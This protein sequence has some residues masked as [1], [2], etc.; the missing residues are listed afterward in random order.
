M[1]GVFFLFLAFAPMAEAATANAIYSKGQTG[2]SKTV[3][4]GDNVKVEVASIGYGEKLEYQELYIKGGPNSVNDQLFRET[5]QGRNEQ[6]GYE[7]G[8]TYNLNTGN[9]DAGTYTIEFVAKGRQSSESTSTLSLTIK[10]K[11]PPQDNNAP[12]LTIDYPNQGQTYNSQVTELRYTPTDAEGNLDKCW[13]STNGGQTNSSKVNCNDG[14]QN[15]FSNLASQAGSN[16]WTVWASDT[17]G[18]VAKESVT[19]TYDKSNGGGNGDQNAP[20]VN[21]LFPKSATYLNLNRA[22]FNVDDPE[23][24]LDRCY[25]SLDGGPRIFVQCSEVPNLNSFNINPSAGK[26]TLRVFAEDKAGNLGQDSVA[27]TVSSK[28]GG[29]GD[30]KAPGINPINPQEGDKLSNNQ[31]ELEL[32]TSE[33]AN[34]TYDVFDRKSNKYVVRGKNLPSGFSKNHNSALLSLREGRNYSVTYFAVDRSGNQK[35]KSLKFSIENKSKNTQ[36]R[37]NPGDGS[38]N[39]GESKEGDGDDFIPGQGGRYSHEKDEYLDQ[40]DRDRTRFVDKKNG[41]QGKEESLFSGLNSSW[42]LPL[43][44]TLI[45]IT[46]IALAFVLGIRESAGNKKPNSK[47]SINKNPEEL[48]RD[49][50]RF[51]ERPTMWY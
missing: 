17:E 12:S 25:Y 19:F 26:Q 38:K 31:V 45:G 6:Y 10:K 20:S 13:Y 2:G 51:Q 37:P 11:Q 30:N 29:G 7:Y 22:D 28:G 16:T 49:Y 18:N 39:K 34:V 43:L 5:K 27:F 8:N 21:I 36:P 35:T 3:T 50:E 32:S 48:Y 40:F 33:D 24:N 4:K 1:I 44:A 15:T 46:M 42:L 41:E 47:K 23:N 9:Y 14:T